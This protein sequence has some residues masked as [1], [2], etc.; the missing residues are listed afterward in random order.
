MHLTSLPLVSEHILDTNIIY[1]LKVKN[2]TNS[3]DINLDTLGLLM[4]KSD[5]SLNSFN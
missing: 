3:L 4:V 5:L 2:E 1:L